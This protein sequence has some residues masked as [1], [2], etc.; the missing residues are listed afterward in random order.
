[1]IEFNVVKISLDVEKPILNIL[2]KFRIRRKNNLILKNCKTLGKR[3]KNLI[4]SNYVQKNLTITRLPGDNYL[5]NDLVIKE[6]IS[7]YGITGNKYILSDVASDYFY[8]N[9]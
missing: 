1:M 3:G 6:I 9:N 7:Q 2:E 8:I 4:I 5:V